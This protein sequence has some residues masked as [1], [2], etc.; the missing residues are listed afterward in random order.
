MNLILGAPLRLR[1]PMRLAAALALALLLAVAISSAA[2]ASTIVS[3]DCG[4]VGA[5][6]QCSTP[7]S[8]YGG[9]RRTLFRLAN[10][11]GVLHSA[12]LFDV[13][14]QGTAMDVYSP[15]V[16]VGS[17]ISGRGKNISSS[18]RHYLIYQVTGC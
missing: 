8:D 10:G 11:S 13:I 6:D 3:R 2:R 1:T 12:A 9:D 16:H 18:A 5:Q 4:D 7:N 17:N 15:C 14:R